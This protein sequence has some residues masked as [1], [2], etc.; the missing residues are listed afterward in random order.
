MRRQPAV[1]IGV[2]ALDPAVGHHRENPA[3]LRAVE[4]A[5][6]FDVGDVHLH[7]LDG[8]VGQVS[9]F[10]SDGFGGR[11]HGADH[12]GSAQNAKGGSAEELTTRDV[13]LDHKFS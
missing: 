8:E 6:P 2:I 3:V 13:T 9:G 11:A 4:F 7:F 12:G 5:H 1:A 10:D